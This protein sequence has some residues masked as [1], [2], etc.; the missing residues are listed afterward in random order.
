MVY[1]AIAGQPEAKAVGEPFQERKQ[2]VVRRF[3]SSP[4]SRYADFDSDL[5]EEVRAYLD[6]LLS[7]QFVGG[8]ERSYNPWSGRHHRVTSFNVVK[9]LR[10]LPC[11]DWYRRQYPNARHILLIRHPVPTALSRARNGW[12]AP[13]EDFASDPRWLETLD[14]R[15]KQLFCRLSSGDLFQ[16][17]LA[18][19]IG[20]HWFL[21]HENSELRSHGVNLV[22]FEHLVQDRDS[23][24]AWLVAV[25]DANDPDG[26][27]RRLGAPSR[28]SRYSTATSVEAMVG[29]NTETL[30]S[31]WMSTVDSQQIA[32]AGELLET[33]GFTGYRAQHSEPADWLANPPWRRENPVK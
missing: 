27:R 2:A 29:G 16:R 30:V 3:V 11:T 8:Y 10:T 6:A 23:A 14:S 21:Q 9:I 17:H 24:G 15:Q 19:W 18:V 12:H 28:S 1:D 26:L 33:F 22:G 20:E 4:R 7:G 25:T 32:I 31:G 13:S 5:G